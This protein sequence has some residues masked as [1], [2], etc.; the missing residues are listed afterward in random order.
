MKKS[1]PTQPQRFV[2]VGTN[3]AKDDRANWLASRF[4]Q[5]SPDASTNPPA[6]IYITEPISQKDWSTANSIPWD[7]PRASFR[8]SFVLLIWDSYPVDVAA[9]VDWRDYLM[10]CRDLDYTTLIC[11]QDLSDCDAF[12]SWLEPQLK[13]WQPTEVMEEPPRIRLGEHVRL[14]VD[15]DDSFLSAAYMNLSFGITQKELEPLEYWRRKFLEQ[16]GIVTPEVRKRIH[17]LLGPA[18][19]Q[20]KAG[21][22]RSWDDQENLENQAREYMKGIGMPDIYASALPTILVTGESGA[23]KTMIAKQIARGF[24]GDKLPMRRVSMPEYEASENHFEHEMFGFRGGSYSDAPD[25]GSPGILL[26]HIGGIIFLDE[27]GDASMSVQ[28]KLLGYMDD[29][30]VSPKGFHHPVFCP[31]LIIAATNQDLTEAVKKRR[32]R[33]ELLER[34][35]VHVRVPSLDERK[36]RDFDM[37]LDEIL[38]NPGLNKGRKITAIGEKAYTALYKHAYRDGNFRRLER[39]IQAGIREAKRA[40]RN[41]LTNGDIK[42][43]LT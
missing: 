30:K 16:V 24:A 36:S 29:Y 37:I 40:G 35:D 14:P 17:E 4:V 15:C 31:T 11:P 42:N 12:R 27:I 34:F 5:T 21:E 1:G 8:P 19:R 32:F 41:T 43:L 22:D 23:G 7:Q 38:Q 39:I 28:R 6:A 2:H 10:S 3:P 25:E 20:S 33:G 13:Q 9:L 26:N 18:L